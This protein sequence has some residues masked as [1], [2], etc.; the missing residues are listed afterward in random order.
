MTP[1]RSQLKI[2]SQS[3]EKKL[4]GPVQDEGNRA[5]R[6]NWGDGVSY[7]R[8]EVVLHVY[9]EKRRGFWVESRHIVSTT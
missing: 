9:Y 4:M 1:S 8:T 5:Q 6:G 3:W 2:A 7:G